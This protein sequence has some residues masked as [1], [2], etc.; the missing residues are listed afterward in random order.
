MCGRKPGA[1]CECVL[2]TE[3]RCDDGL[4]LGRGCVCVFNKESALLIRPPPHLR[5]EAGQGLVRSAFFFWG[6]PPIIASPLTTPERQM[7]ARLGAETASYGPVWMTLCFSTAAC[8]HPPSGRG[9]TRARAKRNR[10]AG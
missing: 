7:G 6:F 9:R 2:R 5:E 3:G 4:T 10:A 8:V 1:V